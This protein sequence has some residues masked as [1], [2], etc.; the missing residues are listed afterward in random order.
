M[1]NISSNAYILFM[2]AAYSN[3]AFHI[4]IPGSDRMEEA[5]FLLD[6]VSVDV[7]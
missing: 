6:L 1:E 4:W 2:T 7:F 3:Y 5:L